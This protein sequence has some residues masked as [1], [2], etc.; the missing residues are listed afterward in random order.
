MKWKKTKDQGFC[1][2]EQMKLVKGVYIINRKA[3]GTILTVPWAGTNPLR[4]PENV[5]KVP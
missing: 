2:D 1:G 3:K 5:V 4:Q